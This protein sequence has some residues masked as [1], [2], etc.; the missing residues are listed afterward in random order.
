MKT[1]GY[2]LSI[3][4]FVIIN[5]KYRDEKYRQKLGDLSMFTI[6]KS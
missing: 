2:F 6:N 5:K 4:W 3:F 1:N